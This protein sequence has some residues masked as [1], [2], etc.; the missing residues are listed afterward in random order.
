MSHFPSAILHR[1]IVVQNQKCQEIMIGSS[2]KGSRDFMA[3]T[4]GFD[5]T[6]DV[7]S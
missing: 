1:D 2:F 3:L 7:E 6:Q 5:K 4:M